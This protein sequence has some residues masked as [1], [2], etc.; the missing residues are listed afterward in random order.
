MKRVIA[1]TLLA[2][3]L[4]AQNNI[5]LAASAAF[6]LE[7]AAPDGF[8]DLTGPQQLVADL[9]Y[10]N[11]QIGAAS[12]SVTPHTV[13]F[14]DPE[15]V[16]QLLPEVLAPET[17]LVLLRQPHP[18]NSDRVCFS[19]R[20]RNCGFI[21]PESFGVIYDNSRYRIDLFFS[22][23][24]LPRI[25]A[26]DSPY[27]PDSSSD[28]S[29]VQNLSGTWSGV[30]ADAGD[31][32]ATSLFGQSILSF[33]ESGLH[34]T[35][36]ATDNGNSQV[37][38]LHWTR[39]Y[40]G[41]AYS[42]G[43]IQP[44][45]GFSSFVSSP[46]L[47][48]VEY[49]S[50]NNSRTDYR[51]NQGSPL[52]INMPVRGRVEIYRDG[53]LI[54]SEL[55]EA[56]NRLLDTSSMPGGAY[57][58]EIRTFD[59]NGR[60]LI[61]QREFFTKDSQLPP[62]GEWR[63]AIQAGKPAR[64][65]QSELLPDQLDTYFVQAG[66]ARR[67]FDDTGLFVNLGASGDQQLAELGGRWIGEY[68]EMSPSLVHGSDGRSG[69]RFHALVK[70]P[71]FS[72]SLMETRLGKGTG[73]DTEYNLL[74]S[75]YRQRNA[76]LTGP[77]LG[78]HLSLRY[79]E[80]DHSLAIESPEFALDTQYTDSNHLATLEYRR[81]F[82]RNRHWHGDLTLAH[83]E[84]GGQGL[85]TATFEFRF[86]DDHWNHSARL[87]GDRGREDEQNTRAGFRSSWRDGDLWAAEVHQQ[88]SSEVAADEYTFGSSTRIAGRRGLLSSTLNYRHGETGG[89]T[90]NYLGSFSTNFMTDGG[91]FA[92][93]GERALSSAVLV[94]IAGGE[95]QQ[96][97]IL[98]DG[99]RRGYASG[100]GRSVVNLP[101]FRSYDIQLRPLAEGFYD[102]R[103]I[104]DTVTLYPGNV[105]A[106]EYKIQPVILVLGR[107]VRDGK[108]V[109]HRKISIGE[110]SAVTDEFGVFQMEMHGDPKFLRAPEVQW[111]GCLVP[112]PEQSTG[113]HWLNLGDINFDAADCGGEADHVASR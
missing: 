77:L 63:W 6:T 5:G 104:Q 13:S 45:H 20:Q 68:L 101:S 65:I 34:S 29:F 82:F 97:E 37:T 110:Y 102:Y 22:P 66:V 39:D 103:E 112:L 87:R 88:F 17:L 10:G 50:S 90:L 26:I 106:A 32:Q 93:G 16:L 70:T 85:T 100:G 28:F 54:A 99:V 78:G 111:G 31:A 25:A 52:E 11:R 42:A 81:D 7:T 56:G 59:E 4:C 2:L 49:R 69:H 19:S 108:P 35:W 27:L 46:Y 53:R 8:A 91:A 36:S 73:T 40:R 67:L 18:S 51:Y 43:I 96:F 76:A 89:S 55:L 44:Q 48:G 12:V 83:S 33:G 38:Q 21:T 94:D 15:A 80:R 105:A 75:G 30:K 1:S 24:L 92:W 113:E 47:Y 107:L 41:R 98:V 23:D 79:S 3:C 57:E 86:R 61:Q 84:A 74:G 95:D 71:L 64:L 58:V 14:N 9:Y 62:P 109:A 60:P 72:L